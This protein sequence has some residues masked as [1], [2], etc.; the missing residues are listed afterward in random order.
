LKT[1]NEVYNVKQFSVFL[2]FCFSAIF[3]LNGC[4]VVITEGQ[5]K[6]KQADVVGAINAAREAEGL[7]PLQVDEILSRTASERAQK[8]A[9]RGSVES[10]DNRLPV[11]VAAGSFARFALSHEVEAKTLDEAA[12]LFVE[13]PISKN[14]VLH[15]HLNSI[16]AGFAQGMGKVYAVVD[17]ARTV[18]LMNLDE[19]R[20]KLKERIDLKRTNNSVE[21]LQFN[22]DLDARAEEVAK[23]FMKGAKSSDELIQEAQRSLTAK[24]FDLGRVAVTFQVTGDVGGVL[25]PSVTSDPAL[26]FAGLGLAQGNH[27]DHEPGSMAVVLFLAEPQTAY[28][29]RRPI[30]NLPQP[31]YAP[32]KASAK[33]SLVDQ[34]WVATLSGNH[35]KAARDFE[36]AYKQKKDPRL[37]YE[38]ARAHARNSDMETALTS[39]REYVDLAEGE[40]KEKAIKMVS[41][42]EKGLSIFSESEEHQMSVE[43]KRFFAL[44]Q[45]LF[46]QE[47]WDGAIDAFQQAYTY[48]KHPDIIYNIGLT[49]CRAGRIGKALDFFDE[50]LKYVPEARNTEES[51]QLFDIGVELFKAGQ[52]EAA[53]KHF[54][55]AY[56]F[57][58]FPELI[59][60][61]ALCH[62][63]L[64]ENDMAVKFFREF[65]DTDPPAEDRKEVEKMIS[66]LSSK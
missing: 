14:K 8:A 4:A 62:K 56:A 58:P 31:K 54:A 35:Q 22:K 47:E 10:D 15:G 2:C 60:N 50:Y 44:G 43:S 32:Q 30:S 41:R 1:I 63:A 45:R 20:N 25:L 28:D 34:A 53:S 51:R 29:A 33:G 61:L 64:G 9:E 23:E 3:F 17:M 39:M 19:E 42:L 59:Y 55:M 7:A 6:Q 12:A 27:A 37:L 49:H 18:P 46:E 65:L 13:D 5:K 40:D 38:A 52:F 11:L 24:N 36:A 26:A 16:G 21:P 48:T 57:L 66:E